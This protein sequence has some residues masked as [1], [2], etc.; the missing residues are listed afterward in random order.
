MT[1]TKIYDILIRYSIAT[2][3]L[4]F[5]AIGVA[6][7][8]KSALGTSPISCPPYVAALIGG[9]TVGEWTAAM[10]GFFILL[11]IALL[12]KQFKLKYLMQIPAAFV[13]GFLTDAAI[14][15]FSWVQADSYIAQF[16]LMI[17]ACIVTAFGIAIEVRSK[18]WMIAGEQTCVVLA[19]VTKR[20]FSNVK[21]FFDCSLVILA[22]AI[23]Y[24][25]FGHW[26]GD[27]VHEAVIREGTFISAV[28]TG[29]VIKLFEKPIDRLI[30]RTID[31]HC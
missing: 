5:V 28:L 10:H 20:K 8:I 7:S 6:L 2:A 9:L 19:E 13:F 17:L 18:A 29:L 22:A 11:Q 15:A 3:G 31:A 4:A 16:T 14:W 12:R 30:G 23:S 26:L 1:K 21:I 24:A 25:A 27:G